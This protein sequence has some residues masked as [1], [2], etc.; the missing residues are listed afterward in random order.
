MDGVVL[1]LQQIGA[2]L[3]AETVP[4]RLFLHGLYSRCVLG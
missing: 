4:W 2:G 3:A 1:V